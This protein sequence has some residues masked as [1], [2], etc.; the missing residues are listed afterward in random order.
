MPNYIQL[1]GYC[2]S[3]NDSDESDDDDSSSDSD[4]E[5]NND[6]DKSEINHDDDTDSTYWWRTKQPGFVDVVPS[7][8]KDIRHHQQQRLHIHSESKL[9]SKR[10]QKHQRRHLQLKLAQQSSS[11]SLMMDPANIIISG[12]LLATISSGCSCLETNELRLD[13]RALVDRVTIV[14]HGRWNENGTACQN[15]T[16]W[17]IR[18]GDTT[19]GD[20]PSRHS[21]QYRMSFKS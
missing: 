4:C 16:P 3:N 20:D 10:L 9:C 8:E 12:F 2:T 17:I 14:Y 15:T 7:D 6:D 21:L 1:D 5:N 13:R 19:Q 11:S 18:T